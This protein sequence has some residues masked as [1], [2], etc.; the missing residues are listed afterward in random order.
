MNWTNEA[1]EEEQ[2][3]NLG[4]ESVADL[5]D[6]AKQLDEQLSLAQ[7]WVN[8]HHLLDDMEFEAFIA[9]IGMEE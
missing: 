6:K 4:C 3:S 8:S 1:F 7:D 9:Y 2:M 5:I